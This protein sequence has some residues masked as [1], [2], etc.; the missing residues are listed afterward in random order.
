MKVGRFAKQFQYSMIGALVLTSVWTSRAQ[1]QDDHM[2][3]QPSQHHGAMGMH[4]VNM[5][6]VNDGKNPPG[7]RELLEQHLRFMQV[8]R[9]EP[10]RETAI[11][12]RDEIERGFPFAL[13]LMEAGQTHRRA[14]FQRLRL[15][16]A[17]DLD[18]LIETVL[19]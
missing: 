14:Q 12:L 10:F 17:R 8:H 4:F 16:P 2:H 5:D 9:I 15:L 1:A 3:A 6:R 13:F 11:R 18:R 19:G 7:S